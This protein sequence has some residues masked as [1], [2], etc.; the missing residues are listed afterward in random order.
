MIS[1]P[2]HCMLISFPSLTHTGILGQSPTLGSLPGQG[3]SWLH[4]LL[5]VAKKNKLKE[6]F[7]LLP[8]FPL[9]PLLPPPPTSPPPLLSPPPSLSFQRMLCFTAKATPVPSGESRTFK[10][11]S[12]FYSHAHFKIAESAEF[13]GMLNEVFLP[14]L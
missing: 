5:E 7:I 3:N 6:T 10:R 13:L 8:L 1:T 14:T 9:H 2:I 4:G 11:G 12:Q